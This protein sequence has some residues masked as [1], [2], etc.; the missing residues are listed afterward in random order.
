[1]LLDTETN[2][3]V[4]R[5]FFPILQITLLVENYLISLLVFLLI[6][7]C[8]AIGSVL[9]HGLFHVFG[10]THAHLGGVIS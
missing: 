5:E 9:E 3:V 8:L 7:T 6:I 4:T 1:M 2:R 10:I